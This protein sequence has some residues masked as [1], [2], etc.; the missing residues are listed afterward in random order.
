LNVFSEKNLREEQKERT[1]AAVL[2]AA[3]DEFERVGFEK[4][5]L[6]AIAKAAGVSAGTVLH[7]DELDRTLQ[8]ALAK[9]GKGPLQAQLRRLAR[10]VFGSYTA[11]PRLAR[12]LLKESLFAEP[13]WSPRFIAQATEVQVA[14]TRL[15]AQA[16]ERREL[17][18][19][20]DLLAA[21]AWLS[22]FY[23]TLISWAQGAVKDPVALV[24]ALTAQHLAARLPRRSTS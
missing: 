19:G 6:R 7:H 5:N 21:V 13:P 2:E 12:V 14:V 17:G 15:H 16:V 8:A 10:A 4:A 1:A 9:P 18:P 11:R 23:F 24:D 20:D 22:F 3:R